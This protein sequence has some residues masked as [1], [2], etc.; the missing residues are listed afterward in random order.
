MFNCSVVTP[1]SISDV[2][3]CV[4]QVTSKH[5]SYHID[6]DKTSCNRLTM[7]IIKKRSVP[8]KSYMS[9]HEARLSYQ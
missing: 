7:T 9:Y 1:L 8:V 2:E 3:S 5:D 4:H 6:C